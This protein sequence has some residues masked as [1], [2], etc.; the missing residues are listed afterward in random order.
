MKLT[1]GLIVFG[2]MF[3]KESDFIY[4]NETVKFE[5]LAFYSSQYK[6]FHLYG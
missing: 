6:W 1:C 2:E 5:T 3:S 4:T